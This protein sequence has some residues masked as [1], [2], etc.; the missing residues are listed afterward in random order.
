MPRR[1]GIFGGAFNPPHHGHL[2][3]AQEARRQL[4]LDLVRILP[5]GDAPHRAIEQP[6]DLRV[7]LARRAL[8]GQAGLELCLDEVERDGPS[9]SVDT[10]AQMKEAEPDTALTL[11]IGADQAEQFATWREPARIGELADVAVAMR[12]DHDHER[13]LHGVSQ[14]IGREPL[15]F[16]MPRV[17]ISSS[18]IRARIARGDAVSHLVPLAVAEAIESGGHYR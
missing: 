1:V 4:G 12:G 9:Y 8:I 3:C 17:D 7:E 11:I 2:I 14:A 18:D 15:T 16:A 10:L 5:T 6:A 13:A